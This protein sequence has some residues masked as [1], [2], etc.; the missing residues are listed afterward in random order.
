MEDRGGSDGSAQ[1]REDDLQAQG[2]S[3]GGRGKRER[4]RADSGREKGQKEGERGQRGREGE[5][6]REII[7]VWVRTRDRGKERGKRFELARYFL[8]PQVK[9]LQRIFIPSISSTLLPSSQGHLVL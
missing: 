2:E 9:F 6:E 8:V 1:R 7:W 4:E 5:R 3:E